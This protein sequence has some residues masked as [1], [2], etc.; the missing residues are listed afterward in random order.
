VQVV[1][2][3]VSLGRKNAG[4]RSDLH[5]HLIKHEIPQLF[6]PHRPFFS[7]IHLRPSTLR[8]SAP[9]QIYPIPRSTTA[10]FVSRITLSI[11][12]FSFKL[13]KLPINDIYHL[14]GIFFT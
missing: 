5:T 8:R 9:Q 11:L 6:L 7:C 10:T 12:P 2:R 4:V 14:I 1:F 3:F 13:T